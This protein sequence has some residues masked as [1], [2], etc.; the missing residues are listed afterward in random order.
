MGSD[1]QAILIAC[2]NKK[3]TGGYRGFQAPSWLQSHLAPESANKLLEARRQLAAFTNLPPGPDLGFTEHS[4]EVEY[5]PARVRY[6]GR[7]YQTA[8]FA[9][10]W[11][12]CR[13]KA[14]L[15]VSALYGLIHPD[16]LIRN[17]DLSMDCHGP[18]GSRLCT[19]WKRHGLGRLVAECVTSYR[20]AMVHDLLSGVY[21]QALGRWLRPETRAILME[22]EFPGL[23]RGAV[24]ARGR[25]LRRILEDP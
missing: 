20:P 2:S 22:H 16:D 3:R 1:P 5:L 6:V 4:T 7:A 8:D 14:V 23:R 19:W 24:Y 25:M 11:P 21:R 12:R 9:N 17:Y 18:D 13:G 10:V 15:I